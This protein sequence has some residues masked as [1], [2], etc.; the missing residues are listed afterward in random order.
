MECIV[1][2]AL[3][4][5]IVSVYVKEVVSTYTLYKVKKHVWIAVIRSEKYISKY[6][7]LMCC[8]PCQLAYQ[9][10]EKKWLKNIIYP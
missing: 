8:I 2:D 7:V 3:F 1:L 10:V 6:V 9:P 4:Y 5:Y